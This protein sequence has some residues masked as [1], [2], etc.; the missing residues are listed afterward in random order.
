MIKK[1][2]HIALIVKDL[3]ES[4]EYYSNMFDFTLRTKGDNGKRYMAFL[5]HEHLPQFEIE[6]IQDKHQTT[7]YSEVGVVNHLAFTVDN[8]EE[9][10]EYYQNKGV[11]FHSDKPNIAIDGAKVIFF[12]G[13]NGELLQLVQP[14]R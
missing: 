10:I 8:M 12:N 5:H 6:L 11:K 13:P 4:I 7:T 14:T 9:A 3:E 1:M 2:E